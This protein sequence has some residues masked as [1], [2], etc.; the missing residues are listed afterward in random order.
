MESLRTSSSKIDRLS[1][2]HTRY[3][4][5]TNSF[6]PS[7][8]MLHQLGFASIALKW[9]CFRFPPTVSCGVHNSPWL[10]LYQGYLTVCVV[11][12][13]CITIPQWLWTL[14]SQVNWSHRLLWFV[15]ESEKTKLPELHSIQLWCFYVCINKLQS[16]TTEWMQ[17][18]VCLRR[19][20]GYVWC[21]FHNG[22]GSGWLSHEI[23]HVQTDS[24]SSW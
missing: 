17:K 3:H 24:S 13:Q 5:K 15:F 7:D 6:A 11:Y 9:T 16:Q 4:Q 1:T 10:I 19:I 12:A 20:L 18:C 22:R 21:I 14:P 23:Q 8:E 2:T